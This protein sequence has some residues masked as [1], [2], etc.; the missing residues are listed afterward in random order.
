LLEALDTLEKEK[1]RQATTLRGELEHRTNLDLTA[2][3]EEEGAR[4]GAASLG[5]GW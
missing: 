1:L 4:E 3:Q 2:K 5:S